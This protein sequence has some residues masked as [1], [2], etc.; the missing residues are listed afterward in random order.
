M[1]S[2][3]NG[4]KK[5][6]QWTVS[7]MDSPLRGLR[8]LSIGDKIQ[9]KGSSHWT[10]HWGHCPLGTQ[11]KYFVPNGQSKGSSHWTVHWGHCPLGTLSIRNTFHWEHKPNILSPMDSPK[12]RLIGLSIGDTVPNIL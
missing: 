8:G 9:S 7:P 6:S 4:Q 3:P 5:C 11:T 2:V 12:D 1:N 10:V